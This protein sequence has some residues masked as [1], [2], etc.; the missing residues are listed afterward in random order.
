[1]WNQKLCLGTSER[2]GLSRFEQVRLFKEVGFEAFFA[3]WRHGEDVSEFVR[4]SK[5]LDI[6]F[7]SIHAPFGGCAD[8][9]GEGTLEEAKEALDELIECVHVCAD[10]Q[11]PIMVSHAYIGFENHNP[12]DTGL[13]NYGKLIREAEKCGIK[14]AFEN[15][16]GEEYLAAI[17]ST[18]KDSPCVGFCWDTGHEMCYNYSKDMLALYGDKLICTHLNDNLGIKDYN[19]KIT[20]IDDLHLLPFDGI[21]DWDNI[22]QRLNR[23]GFSDTLTFELSTVSKPGRHEND[24]YGKMDFK[25]YLSLCYERAC[26]VAAKRL[27]T[28]E[29]HGIIQT[30]F[31]V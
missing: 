2:F 28:E 4:L 30:A 12:T 8:L 11:V 26:K 3:E 14:I 23:C 9:W 1:M 27:K 13:E 24:V 18:F 15:T 7:Q 10:A 22:A 5:E 25:D 20:Y 17:M 21:A 31:S 6:E 29:K 16:E 19:G